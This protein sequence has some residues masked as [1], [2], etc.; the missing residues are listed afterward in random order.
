MYQLQKVF[1]RVIL[2]GIRQI[3][4]LQSLPIFSQVLILILGIIII[5]SILALSFSI[6][7]TLVFAIPGVILCIRWIAIFLTEDDE[8]GA[9]D[10]KVPTFYASYSAQEPEP[11]LGEAITRVFCMPVVGVVFG[12]IHCVG[13]SFHFPSSAGSYAVAGLFGGSYWYC[14]SIPYI[15]CF[16]GRTKQ[17]SRPIFSYC[18]LFNHHTSLCSVT[19]SLVSRGF[20]LP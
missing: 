19:S 3:T 6:L 5:P 12:G 11:G 10:I 20:H 18:I 7:L 17:S 14:L 2:E 4:I 8:I 1:T 15:L 16:Y 9:G 13:W